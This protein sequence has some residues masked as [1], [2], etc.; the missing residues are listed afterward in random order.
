M[1]GKIILASSIGDSF[2]VIAP[3]LGKPLSAQKIVCI[4]TAANPYP[5]EKRGYLARDAQPILDAGA[6]FTTF[7]LANKSSEETARML[8]DA[9]IVYVCGGNSF[10]LL[11][12]MNNVGFKGVLSDFLTRGGVYIGSSAGAVVAC[13]DIGFIAPMD[14]PADAPTLTDYT[15]LRLIDCK[16]VPHAGHARHGAAAQAIVSQYAQETPAIIG[17]NDNQALLV[18]GHNMTLLTERTS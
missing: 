15:G 9:D 2:S 17:L 3:H 16:L 14:N 10:Y 11:E 6:V 18:V 13:P 5:V 7:D 1:T 12:Q 4:P 8:A